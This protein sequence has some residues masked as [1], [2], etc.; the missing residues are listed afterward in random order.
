MKH[1]ICPLLVL[2]M[3]FSGCAANEDEATSGTAVGSQVGEGNVM[4]QEDQKEEKT[5]L[6][7]SMR[8][9]F[10]LNPLLNEEETVDR[11]LK[12]IYE[13]FV[14]IDEM[15]KPVPNIAEN[16]YYSEESRVLNVRIRQGLT[17]H[18][19]SPIT[20]SDVVF[21]INALKQCRDT[22]VYA[23]CAQRILSAE[24]TGENTVA[25]T[26]YTADS[27]NLYALTFP[28][29]SEAYYGGEDLATSEKNFAPLG[30]SI[31]AFESYTPAKELRLVA[32]DNSFSSRP[33]IEHV[34]V[35]ITSSGDTDV[36]SFEQG[37]ID[38]L[39]ADETVLGAV[40][41][42]ENSRSYSFTENYYDFLGFQFENPVLSDLSVRRAIAYAIP[43]ESILEGVYPQNAVRAEAPLNPNSWMNQRHNE[44]Y[45]YN[46]QSARD[47]LAEAGFT[48]AQQE[49]EPLSRNTQEGTERLVFTILVNEEN[50]KR[51]QAAARIAESLNS[52]GF[53][54]TVE[55]V[56]F[57]EYTARLENG[58]FTLFLGGWKLSYM[59]DFGYFFETGAAHNYGHY[60]SA[61]MDAA[62]SAYRQAIGETAMTEAMARLQEVFLAELPYVGIAFLNGALFLNDQIS[63]VGLPTEFHPLEGMEYWQLE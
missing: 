48:S 60:S 26:F 47:L 16:W 2:V 23:V 55:E 21:S 35:S 8:T 54:V 4:Q 53:D 45:G 15:G 31:Y 42:E 24:V 1:L 34:S 33:N 11:I 29:I 6:Y 63:G 37:M 10:T 13:S 17:W 14:S 5:A 44:T 49:G 25:I 22:G 27:N 50:T 57:A 61:A 19:G 41:L 43:K 51:V 12:L 20:P 28:L 52:I 56:P 32:T 59:P 3:I 58:D 38:A 40:N 46:L 39:V 30:N 36:F 18:D 9:A 7:L 62:I